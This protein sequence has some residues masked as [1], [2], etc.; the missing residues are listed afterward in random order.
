MRV[1]AKV[2]AQAVREEGSADSALEQLLGR[3][4]G[5]EDAE[6][7]EARDGDLVGAQ[8]EILPPHPSLHHRESGLLHLG[9]EFVDVC[10]FRVEGAGEGHGAG[11]VGAVAL[12]L[13]ARV[14][15]DIAAAVERLVVVLVVQRRCVFAGAEDAVVGLVFGARGD[16]AGYECGFEVLFVAGGGDGVEDG[17]VSARGD[18]VG[19][20]EE[21][22]FVGVF[23]DAAVVDGGLEEFGVCG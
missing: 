7:L 9:H 4:A 2:M 10:A 13:R 18:G 15:E 3:E 1:H 12:V 19:V 8:V 20:A 14:D 5:A 11:D 23:G 17:G 22:D 21:G 16:A 6:A